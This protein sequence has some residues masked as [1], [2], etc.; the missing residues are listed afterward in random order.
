MI[1][2]FVHPSAVVG[3]GGC[4]VAGTRVCR[5]CDA[6]TS[7]RFGRDCALGHNRFV[8]DNDSNGNNMA[9]Q[10]NVSLHKSVILEDDIFCSPR[11]VFT[12]VRTPCSMFPNRISDDY[13]RSLVERETSIRANASNVCS[14][15]MGDTAFVISGAM[16]TRNVELGGV[17]TGVPACG[18]ARLAISATYSPSSSTTTQSTAG[19]T[20]T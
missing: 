20:G 7:A 8:A 10:N 13:T 5:F 15:P 19:A 2:I 9:V 12:N 18:L 14:L 11:K 4:V 16:V 17:I 3:D 1:D 6:I